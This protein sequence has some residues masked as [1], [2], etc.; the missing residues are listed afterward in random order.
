M[1]TDLSCA[2]CGSAKIVPRARVTELAGDYRG[3]ISVGV[4]ER[5]EAL[6]FKGNKHV[7]VHARVCGECGYSEL[8]VDD[9][10]GLYESYLKSRASR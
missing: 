9:P 8:Y 3:E 10:A 7:N 2:K 5:P 6:V 1:R 4:D